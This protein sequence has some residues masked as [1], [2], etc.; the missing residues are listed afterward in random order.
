MLSQ[1]HFDDA[2]RFVLD[3]A[4]PVDR[5][6][7]L[8]LF[9]GADRREVREALRAF[10]N[11]DGGFGHG[12]EPD[13]RLPDSS[14]TATTVAL[15]YLRDSRATSDDDLVVGAIGYLVEGFDPALDGW[16]PV[17]ESVTDHPHAPWWKPSPQGASASLYLDAEIVGYLHEYRELVDPAFLAARTEAV[18]AIVKVRAGGLGSYTAL[19]LQRLALTVPSTLRTEIFEV[20]CD[21]VPTTIDADPEKWGND[22]QPFWL[23]VE[24]ETPLTEKLA[25]VISASLDREVA[26]Q[27]KDGSWPPRW[28]WSDY[29]EGW[30]IASRE[31]AGEQT[32]RTLRAL[33]QAARLPL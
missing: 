30:Q 17:P 8:H 33:R 14:A 27:A 29:P 9:E 32:V 11:D 23:L 21:E 31:W 22:F 3:R 16:A 25:S 1:E 28:S 26:R 15:Q 4:R 20:L 19:G 6:L 24:G 5:A 7:F 10:Q 13:F 2:R 18:R 12:M